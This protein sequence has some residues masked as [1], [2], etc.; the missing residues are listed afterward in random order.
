MS[1]AALHKSKEIFFKPLQQRLLPQWQAFRLTYYRRMRPEIVSNAATFR[2]IFVDPNDIRLILRPHRVKSMPAYIRF[3]RGHF[4]R[5]LSSG[6]VAAGDWT[7]HIDPYPVTEE[8]LF[9]ALSDRWHERRAWQDTEF[10]ADTLN[11]IA[12][13]KEVWNLCR[14]VEDV[15][16][17]CAVADGLVQSIKRDGFKSN[18][19]PVCVSIGPEG[20]IIKT[21][22]G[23]HRIM[24]AIISGQK[25][26]VQVVVR[27]PDWERARQAVSRDVHPDGA[28]PPRV[29]SV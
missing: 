4:C 21:G 3:R 8:L 19:D 29:G 27:H 25:I 2:Q 15:D 1:K 13:G 11:Q 24:L 12:L 5:F 20:Q 7:A 26:P 14:S 22:N 17:S 18:N 9:H 10:Y 23:Q 28:L 6:F 16:Y